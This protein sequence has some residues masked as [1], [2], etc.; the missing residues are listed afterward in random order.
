M[1]SEQLPLLLLL[2]DDIEMGNPILT[3]VDHR[4]PATSNLFSTFL[5]QFVIFSRLLELL[6]LRFSQ[7]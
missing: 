5:L 3:E 1:V 6:L 7:L 2:Q 4:M